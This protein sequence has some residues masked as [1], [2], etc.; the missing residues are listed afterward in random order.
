VSGDLA[1]LDEGFGVQGASA[2]QSSGGPLSLVAPFD[3]SGD[4]VGPVDGNLREVLSAPARISGGRGSVVLKAKSSVVTPAES[5]YF[6]IM[7]AIAV[8]RF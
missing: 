2:T 1:T 4:D 6:E 7:T 3:G 5:D 8:A